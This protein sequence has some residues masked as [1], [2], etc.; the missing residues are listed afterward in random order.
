[1]NVNLRKLE[2]KEDSRGK[3]V[4][5]LKPSFVKQ[6]ITGQVMIATTFPGQERGRHYHKRKIE[7]YSVIAGEGIL[8]LRDN[9]TK[10]V[11]EIRLTGKEMKLI[12]IPPY[13]FHWIRNVGESEMILLVYIDEEFNET[14]PATYYDMQE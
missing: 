5:I 8:S 10:K 11:E 3:L 2:I 7:W 1:M 6:K 4:E 9:N 14:D 12:E 13:W